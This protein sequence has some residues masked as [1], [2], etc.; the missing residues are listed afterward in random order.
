M[1]DQKQIINHDLILQISKNVD[2]IKLDLNQFEP[3]IDVLCGDR[4]YQKEAIRSILRYFLGGQ[5]GNL[6]ELA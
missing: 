1:Q 6:K 5:Y 2:P 3:F 4:E